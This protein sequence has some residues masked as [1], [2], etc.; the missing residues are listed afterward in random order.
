VATLDGG[1]AQTGASDRGDSESP[2]TSPG[3]PEAADDAGASG[4]QSSSAS[5][6]QAPDQRLT[7]EAYYSCLLDAGL[8]AELQ[9][10]DP[11][12]A[13]G[14]VLVSF[15]PHSVLQAVPGKGAA[16]SLGEDGYGPIS[17]EEQQAFFDAHSD[18]DTYGLVV[19]GM[20]YSADFERC[21]TES[22]YFEP[23]RVSEGERQR[24]NQLVADATNTWIACAR[25][26]G[27]PDLADVAART[28]DPDYYPAVH[29][30]LTMA[31]DDL[32]ALLDDCPNFDEDATREA[33]EALGRGEDVQ[34][35]LMPSIE[36]PLPEGSEEDPGVEATWEK[37]ATIL[38]EK[39]KAFFESVSN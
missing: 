13:D 32:R 9:P 11:E 2:E 29:L 4:G 18:P 14:A 24:Q 30:P 28:D 10:V 33:Y 23:P 1:A 39:E 5:P 36:F 15:G 38:W 37:L 7:A 34:F 27:L 21:Y 20:D 17:E 8:P 12:A 31:E 26:H 16:V 35:P 3:S 22:G 6:T 19:D 25:E